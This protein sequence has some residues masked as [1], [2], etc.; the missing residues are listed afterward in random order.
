M[1]R[2][3][4][5]CPPPCVFHP[6][7]PQYVSLEKCQCIKKNC[8]APIKCNTGDM[9]L[10]KYIITCLIFV[11]LYNNRFYTNHFFSSRM[12][13]SYRRPKMRATFPKP[14]KDS[15]CFQDIKED[16]FQHIFVKTISYFVIN[17][18]MFSLPELRWYKLM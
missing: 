12:E 6:L 5:I 10:C 18:W 16:V 14:P 7:A 9:I 15:K 11:Q 1:S 2:F 4:R 8:S 17:C 13:K 3:Q